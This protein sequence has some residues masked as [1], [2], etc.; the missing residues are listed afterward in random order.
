MMMDTAIIW[1]LWDERTG[2]GGLGIIR[3][4][5]SKKTLSKTIILKNIRKFSSSI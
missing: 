3:H 4:F 5:K 2:R 1:Y